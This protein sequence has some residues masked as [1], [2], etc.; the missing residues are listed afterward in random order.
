MRKFDLTETII[1]GAIFVH[2]AL[3][4]GLLESIYQTCLFR[5]LNRIG[6]S[7]EREMP[8]PVIFDETDLIVDIDWI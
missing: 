2:R 7:V 1:G 3:G 4:P 5:R 8:L 6:L